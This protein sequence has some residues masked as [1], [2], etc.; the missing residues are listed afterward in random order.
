M[1]LSVLPDQ[2]SSVDAKAA[3][4]PM[5]VLVVDDQDAAR[6]A[7]VAVLDHAGHR[8]LEAHN[9]AWAM[10]LFIRHR[11]DVVLLDVEMPG[12]NGYCLARQLRAAENGGWTPILFLSVHASD[13]DLWQGIEAG[14]DDYLVKPVRKAVLLTKLRAMQ[15]LMEMR[16][17]LVSMSEELREANAQLMNLSETDVLTGLVNR[18]GFNRRL[19]Q[20]FLQARRDARPLSLFLCDIDHFKAYNDALGH[21]QGDA[22]LRQVAQV[23][24]AVCQRPL[25]CAA[26]YGGEE[27][28]LILPDTPKSGAM[29]LARTL[30]HLLR[31]RAL[32]HPA[33][34]ISPWL[35][36]SGGITTCVPDG[37]GTAESLV[38]RADEA[39]YVAKTRGRNR[40]FSFEMQMDTLECRGAAAGL[41]AGVLG[42]DADAP[43]QP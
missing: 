32:P 31:Q 35:T 11:P 34:A 39:L 6:V 33:S 4:R 23:L 41:R 14:G 42:S 25:D 26:R 19:H 17:R 40:F 24:Q 3:Y 13:Q 30:A 5:T 1:T 16:Q 28:A 8:V 43:S 37:T 2:A 7:L 27:F 12:D 9:A 18:R 22:C 36:L 15:R 10:E 21:V 20:A 29:T 38:L